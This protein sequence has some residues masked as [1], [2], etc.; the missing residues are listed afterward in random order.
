MKCD[1]DQ[2]N[3]A[4]IDIINL[5]ERARMAISLGESHFREFKSVW[6]GAPGKKAARDIKVIQRDIGEALVAFANADGGELLVGVEDNGDITGIDGLTQKEIDSLGQAPGTQV[7]GKTPLPPIRS[8]KVDIDGKH[9]LYFSVHKS[10]THVHLTA[11]GRCVQRRDLETAPI[12]P[13]EILFERRERESREYDREYVDGASVT[14]LDCKLVQTVAEQISPGMSVEKCLQYLDLAEYVGPGLRIRSAALLLFARK[15]PQWHPRLQ[16]RIIKV[17]GIELHTGS[18]YNVE[19]DETVNGNILQLIETGWEALRPQLVQTKLGKDARFGT[20]VMYPELACREALV[21]A[22]A[23]RDY[24]EEGRGIEIY[25]F[26]DRMEI[27]NPG[28]LLSSLRIEDLLRLEGAHQSRNANIARVLRELGYMQELGEGVRRMFELMRFSELTPPE[29]VSDSQS[30]RVTLRYRTIYSPAQKLWLDEFESFNLSREQKAIIVLGREGKLISPQEIWDSLGIVDTEH[31]RQLIKSLQDIGV[32]RSEVA[33]PLAQKKARELRTSVRKVPRF[34][35]GVPKGEAK[36]VLIKASPV[37][38][39]EDSTSDNPNADARLFLANLPYSISE[40]TL[41]EFL[42][43]FGEVQNLYIPRHVDTGRPKGYAFV[44]FESPEKAAE[45][46]A[47]LDGQ[48]LDDR[49]IVVRKAIPR[50]I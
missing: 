4:E 22:I 26:D 42:S 25:V 13:G 46:R 20:T 2:A 1:G 3:M 17:K 9:I 14:D 19:S 24:S 29:I 50:R 15:P 28:A 34:I 33:K 32:L 35:I 45:I 31:Y 37:M 38:P 5:E 6:H 10:A 27:R 16:L 21:N 12:P 30:F 7:H 49:L 39:I 47:R 44:E 40:T 43:T 41:I 18:R 11:D 48:R 23:H 36:N 8:A